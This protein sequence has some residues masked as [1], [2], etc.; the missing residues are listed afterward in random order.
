[1][2][3]EIILIGIK[4]LTNTGIIDLGITRTR[5]NLYLVQ[6]FSTEIQIHKIII[7]TKIIMYMEIIVKI[8]TSNQIFKIDHFTLEIFNN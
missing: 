1:M 6:I 7:V 8:Q 2:K 3:R 5:T 4:I